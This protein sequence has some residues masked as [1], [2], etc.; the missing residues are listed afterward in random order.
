MLIWISGWLQL[1]TLCYGT[2]NNKEKEI[3]YPLYRSQRKHV[4]QRKRL[5]KVLELLQNVQGKEPGCH[6]NV[7]FNI[8]AS[9]YPR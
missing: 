1:P 6:V 2:Y 4:S 7:P 3:L 8:L 9:K 5:N